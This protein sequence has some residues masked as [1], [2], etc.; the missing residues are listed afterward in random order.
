MRYKVRSLMSGKI[1]V[2]LVANL[3]LGFFLTAEV[4][5]AEGGGECDGDRPCWCD[6]SH[7]DTCLEDSMSKIVP[8]IRDQWF[9]GEQSWTT[10]VLE[11][12]GGAPVQPFE[13]CNG[14]T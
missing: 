8:C 4:V 10:K 7:P 5:R 13:Y 3:V 1:G 6:P 12:Q 14:I 9:D 2:L 11:E